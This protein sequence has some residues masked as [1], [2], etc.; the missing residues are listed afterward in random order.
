MKTLK[1]IFRSERKELY[2][3]AIQLYNNHNYSQAIEKFEAIITQ[4]HSPKSLYYRLS[5]FYLG[6]ARLKLGILLFALGNFAR[7]VSELEKAVEF[8]PENIDIFEYLGICYNN[9]GAFEKATKAFNYFI[10]RRPNALQTRLK[11]EIVYHNNKMW[12]KSISIC[13]EILREAPNYADVHFHLGLSYLGKGEPSKAVSSFESALRIN[14]RYREVRIKLGIIFAYLGKLDEALSQLSQLVDAFP[15]YADLHYFLGIVY[16]CRAEIPQAIDSFG[17]ALKINPS[18]RSARIKLGML[19][20]KIGK[21]N[22]AVD[23]FERAQKLRPEDKDFNIVVDRL[24]EVVLL[25]PYGSK[26][27]SDSL[28]EVIGEEEIIRQTIREFNEHLEITPSFTEML[29]IVKYFP[30]ED[31]SLFESL[32]PVVNKYIREN[33]WHPDLHNALGFLCVKA[34]R[35]DEGEEAFRKA[36]NINP[37]YVEARLN[38][39]N[40]LQDQ[41]KCDLAIV[42]GEILLQK[43]LSY[44]DF[45]CSLAEIYIS[46]GTLGRAEAIL[47]KAIAKH[48]K[49]AEAHFLSAKV[50][51]NQGYREK[52][53]E[54]LKK[55]IKCEPPERLEQKANEILTRLRRQES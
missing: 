36:L 34:K 30:E 54:E 50:Y 51:E 9:I 44:P 21:F 31:F 53:M 47:Q 8:N 55:C 38:L 52:A 20:C 49:Y 12:D 37:E 46:I 2:K 45:Y 22:E 32:I 10:E 13:R 17:Q 15:E 24:R 33:P 3:E 18:F 16:A 5:H 1:R 48:P 27:V 4:G 41:G 39:F 23:E 25:Y 35:Y 43:E 28:K 29:S 11:L 6:Q 26:E 19:L 7:A 42:E 40:T 14:P